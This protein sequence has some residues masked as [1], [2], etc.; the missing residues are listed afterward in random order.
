MSNN[1]EITYLLILI[2]FFVLTSYICFVRSLS[3]NVRDNWGALVLKG[4]TRWTQ[5]PKWTQ[6]RRRISDVDLKDID[7]VAVRYTE[8]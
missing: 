6:R 8:P 1:K 3:I 5:T 4:C 7:T 2:I